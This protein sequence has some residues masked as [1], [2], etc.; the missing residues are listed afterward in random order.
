MIKWYFDKRFLVDSEILF[1]V[2]I[3]FIVLIILLHIYLVYKELK[4]ENK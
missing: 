2:S 1:I 4:N 3:V